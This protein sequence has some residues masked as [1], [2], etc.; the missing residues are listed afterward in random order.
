MSS[1]NKI[2]ISTFSIFSTANFL[3][4]KEQALACR[5]SQEFKKILDHELCWVQQ[6]KNCGIDRF[7]GISAKQLMRDISTMLLDHD[8][9]CGWL[10]KI[11]SRILVEAIQ[12]IYVRDDDGNLHPA[13]DPIESE[14]FVK[15]TFKLI[16]PRKTISMT[17]PH[18]SPLIVEDEKLIKD[19]SEKEERVAKKLSFPLTI[20]NLEAFMEEEYSVGYDKFSC[21]LIFVQHGDALISQS[22]LFLRTELVFK[23]MALTDQEESAES[24]GLIIS[25]LIERIFFNFV[26]YANSRKM[27]DMVDLSYTWARTST[28]TMD[29][30]GVPQSAGCVVFSKNLHVG[31]VAAL[32]K[33]IAVGWPC[34]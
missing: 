10:N 23:N 21:P 12:R 15:D 9:L 29:A 25:S 26:S 24:H 17:V 11:D 30:L 31:Y 33:S 1:I 5:V 7:D 32:L 4:P 28:Y 8:V 6:R 13:P 2:N 34:H 16:V 27:I 20:N 18:N 19:Y 14:K 22:L 3:K